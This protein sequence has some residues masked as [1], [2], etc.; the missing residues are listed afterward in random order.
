MAYI[1]AKTKAM[2]KASDH[3]QAF[4]EYRGELK[5]DGVKP[6]EY[7]KLALAKFIPPSRIYHELPPL[8]QYAEDENSVTPAAKGVSLVDGGVDAP[9]ATSPGRVKIPKNVM[10]KSGSNLDAIDYVAKYLEGGITPESIED[11]PCAAAISMLESYSASRLRKNKFWDEIYTKSKGG[12]DKKDAELYDGE[13]IN[14]KID[15]ILDKMKEFKDESRPSRL[16]PIQYGQQ[17]PGL[18]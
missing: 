3:W 10:K 1:G 12:G 9:P 2:L 4:L 11:A 6:S 14:K 5:A 13:K 7:N 15:K 17:E 8:P 16:S 18:S